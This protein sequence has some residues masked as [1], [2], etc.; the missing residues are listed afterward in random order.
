MLGS[1]EKW[2]STTELKQE[3]YLSKIFERMDYP[4][5]SL[6]SNL[7]AD[8]AT[9]RITRPLSTRTQWWT[10]ELEGLSN[11]IKNVRNKAHRRPDQDLFKKT[12]SLK[13]EL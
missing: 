5:S 4:Q 10:K 2:L 3:R 13:K 1:T 7:I 8:H 11:T 12:K 9:T 6:G